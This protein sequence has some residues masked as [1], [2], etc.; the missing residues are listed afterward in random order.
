MYQA[1]ENAAE[2]EEIQNIFSDVVKFV[3]PTD[4]KVITA[5]V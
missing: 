3:E 5:I 4:S 1:S 2:L